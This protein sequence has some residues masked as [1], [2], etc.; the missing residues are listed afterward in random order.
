[1]IAH[2]LHLLEKLLQIIALLFSKWILFGDD[3]LPILYSW[4]PFYQSHIFF[5]KLFIFQISLVLLVLHVEL[6]Q[7]GHTGNM[8]FPLNI[9]LLHLLFP[10]CLYFYIFGIRWLVLWIKLWFCFYVRF[11]AYGE[12]IVIHRL[13]FGYWLARLNFTIILH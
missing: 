12:W 9:L 2:L 3:L 7:G 5:S 13:W 10:C 1:M 4:Q 11:V 8:L 6:T